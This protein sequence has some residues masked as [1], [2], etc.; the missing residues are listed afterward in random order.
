MT[1]KAA[2]HNL[3][4]K[5]NEYETEA[6]KQLLANAGYAI[7]PFNERADVYVVNTCTV[8]QMADKKSRQMLHKARQKN[9]EAVVVAAGCYVQEAKEQLL[10]DDT[11]DIAIG[12][13]EKGRLPEILKDYLI[14]PENSRDYVPEI[15]K[16]RVY[17]EMAL[18]KPL[19]RTRAFVKIQDG[20]NQFC[21]YCLIPFARGRVRS[22]R[23]EDIIREV[24]TLAQ[25][26]AKEVV[27][28]GI[29]ISSYGIDFENENP[30]RTPK[31]AE[32]WTN[33]ALLD[34]IFELEKIDGIER[35]RLGS[36]EP[37]IMTEKFVEGIAG[38]KKMCPH[39]HLS[40]QS[41][42]NATLARMNRRYTAEEFAEAVRRLRKSFQDPAITTDIIAGFAGETNEEFEE[43]Y[44]FVKNIHFAKTH[45]FK[46]S[47]R[48]RTR[49]YSMPDQVA[50]NIK[51]ERS[52]R[53]IALDDKNKYAYALGFKDRDFEVLFEEKA[54]RDGEM[55]W[56]GHSR[57]NLV[58]WLSSEDSLENEIRVCR[59]K[60]ITPDGEIL[61]GAVE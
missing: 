32:E 7:V 56:R 35:I 21:S 46:F 40:L 23:Q 34:L 53:L 42:S 33:E 52:S 30:I 44:D 41:G 11:I 29:H 48:K 49:A 47:R 14:A 39:F 38:C 58:V 4:C 27:L 5:V 43:T 9:P 2:F 61:A 57:E 26:G 15:D 17:E 16:E 37:G 20:C 36:L 45:I 22:R 54:E 28:S 55:L 24:S 18:D 8:T 1:M 3:G 51:T 12:N 25:N 10:A 13:N 60:E 59:A 31:A 6:M 50:E 19:D